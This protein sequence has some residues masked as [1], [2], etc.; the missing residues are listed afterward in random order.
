MVVGHSGEGKVDG[1]LCVVGRGAYPVKSTG[2]SLAWAAA[3]CYHV[4]SNQS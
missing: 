3:V 2:Q 1:V 4:F